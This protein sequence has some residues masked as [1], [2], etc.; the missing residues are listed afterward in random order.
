MIFFV[1]IVLFVLEFMS[2]GLCSTERRNHSL[3]AI[4]TTFVVM[5]PVLVKST[6][7]MLDC[8]KVEPCNELIEE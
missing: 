5:Y 1:I 7:S 3:N 8:T 4:G 6:F 2:V